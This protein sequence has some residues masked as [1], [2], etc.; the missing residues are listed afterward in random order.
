MQCLLTKGGYCHTG[1]ATSR[2][3]TTKLETLAAGR[4]QTADRTAPGLR[5]PRPP[6]CNKRPPGNTPTGSINTSCVYAGGVYLMV[7]GTVVQIS[8]NHLY[9]RGIL[10]TPLGDGM[11]TEQQEVAERKSDWCWCGWV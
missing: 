6:R 11:L 9:D 8:Y 2:D 3:L 7:I 1:G 5:P 10:G 4:M